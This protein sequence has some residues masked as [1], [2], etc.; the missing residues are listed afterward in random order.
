MVGVKSGV[1]LGSSWGLRMVG[2]KSGW[3][4]GSGGI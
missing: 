1:G 2:V 4:L 3:C